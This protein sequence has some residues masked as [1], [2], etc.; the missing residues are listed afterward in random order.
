[1]I[2][3]KEL[4]NKR[5]IRYDCFIQ[6]CCHVVV[7]YFMLSLPFVIIP[8]FN[9][10]DTNIFVSWMIIFIFLVFLINPRKRVKT[11]TIFC[12]AANKKGYTDAELK[13]FKYEYRNKST[14]NIYKSL[15]KCK[16]NSDVEEYIDIYFND[17]NLEPSSTIHKFYY[18]ICLYLEMFFKVTF[19]ILNLYTI[20]RRSFKD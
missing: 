13:R 9:Q 20:L 1:M 10:I 14:L 8:P 18:K 11:I 3:N 4:L 7:I 2:L 6:R 17:E 12:E 19:E 15:L 16:D 5:K